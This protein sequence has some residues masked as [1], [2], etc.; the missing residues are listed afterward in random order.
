MVVTNAGA[1]L[2][3]QTSGV[4][5]AS[6]SLGPVHFGLGSETKALKAEITWPSG[7]VQTLENVNPDPILK[8]S[9]PGS[10]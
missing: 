5:Y 6:S 10:K 7:V 1:Q 9:E 3:H 4:C 8:V 2:N